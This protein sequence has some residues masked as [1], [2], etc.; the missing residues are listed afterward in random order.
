MKRLLLIILSFCVFSV[1]FSFAQYYTTGA[2][3]WHRRWRQMQFGGISLVYDS[4]VEQQAKYIFPLIPN[5][6]LHVS[7]GRLWNRRPFPVLFHSAH[8]Y[9]NGVVSWAP[10]RMELYSYADTE[11]DC[12]P[13]LRHLA[14]HEGRHAWQMSLVENGQTAFLNRIFGQQAT[15]LVLGLF[16]PKWLL[17]GDAVWYEYTNTRGGR[18]NNADWF[19]QDVAIALNNEMPS[20]EQS[21]FGSYRS[22]YPDFYHMG[23]LLVSYGRMVCSNPDSADLWQQVLHEC[24]R[25][26]LSVS[27]FSRKLR[28]LTGFRKNAFY[29]EAVSYWYAKFRDKY[30]V[31]DSV[32]PSRRSSPFVSYLYPQLSSEGD[33]VA[34]RT[35]MSDIPA[36]VKVDGN[37]KEKV[38]LY[39]SPRSEDR[40]FLHGD[41]LIWSER[42]AHPRWDNASK[43]ILKWCTLDGGKVFS[44][45]RDWYCHLMS[46]SVSPDGNSVVAVEQQRDGHR[47]IVIMDFQGS[48]SRRISFPVPYEPQSPVLL[49]HN[50]LAY[51]LLSDDGKCIVKHDLTT[52][53]VVSTVP[54]YH[55]IRNLSAGPSGSLLYSSDASG[56][57]R[58]YSINENLRASRVVP[59]CSRSLPSLSA[60]PSVGASFPSYAD[61]MVLFSTY[62]RDGYKPVVVDYS[63]QS[64]SSFVVETQGVSFST[65]ECNVPSSPYS[66]LSHLFSVHSWAPVNINASDLSISA[67]PSVMSQNLIGTLVTQVGMNL[68][69]NSDERFYANVDYSAWL[70]L[71]SLRWTN[72]KE[73]VSLDRVIKAFFEERVSPDGVE[74]Q[75]TML[76]RGVMT[77]SNYINK[78]S[79][80]FSFPLSSVHGAWS[81]SV[82]V[83]TSM[84]YSNQGGY[85]LRCIKYRVENNVATPLY[86]VLIDDYSSQGSLSL[87][88]HLS[89]SVVRRYAVRQV[90]PRYGV[91]FSAALK[92]MPWGNQDY[93][94][95]AAAMA[96]VYL[97]GIG[98]THQIASSLGYQY[99]R[100]TDNMSKKYYVVD[101]SL[102]LR[103]S[104]VYGNILP[105]P[106]GCDRV[107]SS[108]YT[109]LNTS[110]ALP[111]VDPDLSLGP[112]AHIKRVVAKVFY[113]RAWGR[114]FSFDNSKSMS[115]V[116]RSYGLELVSESYFLQLPYPVNIGCR[117]SRRPES[118][119]FN[120]QLLLSVSFR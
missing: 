60:L 20:Y 24:G 78:V 92:H 42:K 111:L 9:S 1:A 51:I 57:N 8:A 80:G 39:P 67:G 11:S 27:P 23:L 21:F 34:Y 12:V 45:E 6:F 114:L 100:P 43:S 72:R 82:S 55:N 86:D 79:A 16:V 28:G 70:P 104:S 52:D 14:V 64:D 49:P 38:V 112:V 119:D 73:V 77:G 117:V 56:E 40:F 44:I 75:D 101:G 120:T 59:E 74:C 7:N 93:G 110:Y 106:R 41:T 69:P 3:P 50:V 26:P 102:S 31:P 113:D 109:L 68:D 10:R 15:G 90:G 61:G 54:E 97:P 4:L 17:E 63:V 37:G 65:A 53:S 66:H 13:W 98:H 88:H 81:R 89:A 103:K 48:V 29:K 25:T 99:R 2:D 84:E 108:S 76:W 46:P 36:F 62:T 30:G 87:A 58:V 94:C 115:Y 5:D 85:D 47:D 18:P 83:G 35:G 91:A 105:S 71:L 33:I 19:Q 32:A 22:F 96:T 107:E 116:Q 95:C 118:K